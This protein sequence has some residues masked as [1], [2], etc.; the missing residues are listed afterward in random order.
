[1]NL[2]MCAP[3]C[4]SRGKVRYFIG[5]QVDV[6]GLVKECTEMQSLQ[7]LLEMQARGE[8]PPPIHKPSL[9]K[10]DELRE[11]GEMLN[12]GELATVRK[13]GGRMHRETAE[14]DADSIGAQTPQPR[15][16]IKEPDMVNMGPVDRASGRLSGIY[17]HVSTSSPNSIPLTNVHQYLLVRPYPALRILFASPSQR[18]PGILQSPFMNKIGGSDRVREELTSAMAEGRG[19]TAKVRWVS[20]AGEEGRSRWIHC[21]PL[22]GINGHIGVWM[23]VI[24]DDEGDGSARRWRQAP[25]V[26]ASPSRSQTPARERSRRVPGVPGAEARGMG[27]TTLRNGYVNGING[28]NGVNGQIYR[29]EGLRE[30]VRSGSESLSSLRIG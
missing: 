7:K 14:D 5:A 2:L 4:D 16:L 28:V 30:S 12:Q 19:V 6:S 13:Y 15:L 20:K 3:L 25:P 1:M 24:V 9:E 27:N 23:V 11:L 17:Q 8:D 18:V 29:E 22:I 26:P 10:N 21:T